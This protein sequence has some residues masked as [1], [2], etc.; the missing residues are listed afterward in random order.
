MQVLHIWQLGEMVSPLLRPFALQ[1]SP[2]FMDCFNN[3]VITLT[4]IGFQGLSKSWNM[5][6][7][8][9][10]HCNRRERGKRRNEY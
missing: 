5:F 1:H 4:Q 7:D 2:V 10:L 3:V 8:C 6:L 9:S